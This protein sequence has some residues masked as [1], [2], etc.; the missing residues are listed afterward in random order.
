MFRGLPLLRQMIDSIPDIVLVLNRQR[1][2]VFV[3]RR[4]LEFVGHTDPNCI[5]GLRPGEI[6]KCVHEDTPGGCGTTEFCSTCGAV[7]AILQAQKGKADTRECRV[8][9]AVGDSLDLRVWATPVDVDGEAF[10]IF[11]VM[12]I[13]NEKR[14]RVLERAFF[15]DLLNTAGGLRAFTTLLGEASADELDT[16][17]DTI[18]EIADD[19][20]EQIKAQRELAAAES[21]ELSLHLEPVDPRAMLE[22]LATMYRRHEVGAGKGLE[23]SVDAAPAQIASD[24]TLLKRVLG[25][26]IKN[27]LEA[28]RPGDIVTAGYRLDGAEI[29]FEV[30]NPT[31][32][33]RPVQLQLFQRSFSTKGAGRGIG[34]Y[35]MR[36]L[37]ER[38]LHGSITF[39]S[40]PESGTRFFARYPLQIASPE[41]E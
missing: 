39:T 14:R 38:Y 15:H 26:M 37:S 21:N 13:S 1:Q 4:I 7:Q 23:I 19:M 31:F 5:L 6:L 28:S 41:P 3:N 18:Y 22:D 16:Y 9:R 33:P 25:N 34:T 17:K 12:D 24:R 2:A 30:H 11:S 35:S 40:T 32:M 27:A 10:T 8:T 29:V 20:I 36:L